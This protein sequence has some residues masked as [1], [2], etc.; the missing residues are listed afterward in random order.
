MTQAVYYTHRYHR[1]Q[2]I[3]GQLDSRLE[4]L[5]GLRY[6]SRHC[7]GLCCLH[8]YLACLNTLSPSQNQ[9][10]CP[11]G[12]RC[13]HHPGIALLDSSHHYPSRRSMKNQ[14]GLLPDHYHCLNHPD[15]A[16]SLCFQCCRYYPNILGQLSLWL[17]RHHCLN[18]PVIAE[19]Y[20]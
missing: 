9:T 14:I 18:H 6:Q 4:N 11:L 5:L 10:G 12:R 7:I 3:L 16:W 19:Q 15:I 17:H 20:K 1:C 13:L 8:R 2:N